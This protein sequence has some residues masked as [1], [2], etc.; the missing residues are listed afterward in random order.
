MCT[1]LLP[2]GVNPIAV[3]KYIIYH[4]TL[5]SVEQLVEALSYK[6]EGRGF[7][8]HYGPGFDSATNRNEYRE[9]FLGDKG[10]RCL[11]LATLP[12]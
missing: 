2:P 10:G 7:W 12:P 8:P 6:A 4:N 3:N 11:G 5:H 9:Y 1:V